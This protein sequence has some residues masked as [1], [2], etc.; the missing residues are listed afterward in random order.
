M[1]KN[2][3]IIGGGN[4]GTAVA[5]ELTHKKYNVF[6]CTS[7]PDKFKNPL[8]LIDEDFNTTL[9]ENIYS[10]SSSYDYMLK[11]CNI[12]IVT[13]P[14]NVFNSLNKTL[15]ENH[16]KNKTFIILPGTG[17]CEFVFKD[18]LLQNNNI[19]GLQRVPAVYRLKEYGKI[20]T[21]SGRKKDGLYACSMPKLKEE[22]VIT[23]IENL[24]GLH[25]QILPNYLN[26]TLTPSNPIL[27]TTRLYSLFSKHDKDFAYTRNP[28]FYREWDLESSKILIAC[29]NELMKVKDVLN[30]LDLSYVRS[31][32]VHYESTDEESLTNKISS[33][34]SLSDIKSPMI[35]HGEFFQVDWSSR[36]FVAD[37]PQGLIIIKSICLLCNISTPN[38]DKV[39]F[40]YQKMAEKDYF[41]SALEFGKDIK[42]CNIPQNYGIN[43]LKELIDYYK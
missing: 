21:I 11:N 43:S 27:H 9:S 17:G 39:I 18:L 14:S 32:L 20:A 7:H 38:I 8:V 31:L 36:Y 1:E 30:T 34:K 29:N 41:I 16:V 4:I 23:L 15:M 13:L 26:V 19:I 22:Y 37:F 10:I 25:C 24:F 35:E 3:G 28:Y 12:I 5:I 40:W 2:I 33:I 6:L 42:E